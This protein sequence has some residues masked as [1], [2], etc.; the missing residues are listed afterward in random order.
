MSQENVE[1]VRGLFPGP[2]D[3]ARALDD[4]QEG[5]GLRVLVEQVMEPGSVDAG[6]GQLG[7]VVGD[8]EFLA[9]GHGDPPGCLVVGEDYQK[10]ASFTTF[11]RPIRVFS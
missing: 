6:V 7:E 2:F 3:L 11:R 8:G 5:E 10:S 4:P 1:I 9:G